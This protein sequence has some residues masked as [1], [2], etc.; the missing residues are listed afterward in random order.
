M[1]RLWLPSGFQV[2]S[3]WPLTKHTNAHLVGVKEH[4]VPCLHLDAVHVP[5]DD[6][7]DLLEHL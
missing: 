5:H 6:V 4:D 7:V 2:A 3:K 1:L